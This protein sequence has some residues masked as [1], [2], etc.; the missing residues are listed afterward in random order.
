VQITQQRLDARISNGRLAF[1]LL[2]HLVD[3]IK[4]RHLGGLEGEE[5]AHEGAELVAAV[6]LLAEGL[7]H[8]PPVEGVEPLLQFGRQAHQHVVAD[9]IGLGELPAG[10]VHALK[11]QLGIVLI[12][13]EGHIHHQQFADAPADHSQIG[14]GCAELFEEELVVLLDPG[15][16][17]GWQRCRSG[18]HQRH[19]GDAIGVREQQLEALVAFLMSAGEVGLSDD[20]RSELFDRLLLIFWQPIQ[21]IRQGREQQGDGGEPLLAIDHQLGSLHREVAEALVDVNHRADEVHTDLIGDTSA[22]NV[23]PE[24][25]AFL[26]RPRIGA[27]INRNDELGDGA[28]DLEELGFCGFH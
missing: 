13:G 14:G 4:P 23:R 11:D 26:Q 22:H 10:G 7:L 24:L 18:I 9:Q 28:Q 16:G 8:R 15:R 2:E 12:A 21:H 25:L 1:V 20:G 5:V 17:L 19:Q 6:G 27:L 3:Q